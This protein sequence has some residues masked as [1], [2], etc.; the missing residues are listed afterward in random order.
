MECAFTAN[1]LARLLAPFGI[2]PGTIRNGDRTP[3]GYLLARFEDDFARY[4]P[5]EGE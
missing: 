3:K 4:L 2:V 5:Q 1:G